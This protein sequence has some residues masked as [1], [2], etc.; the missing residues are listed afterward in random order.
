M[1]KQSVESQK[2]EIEFRKKLFQQQVEGKYIFNDEFDTKGIDKIL[3]DRMQKTSEQMIFL[4]KT[5][6]GLSPFIEIGAER[7]QRSLVMENEIGATGCAVDISYDMLRSCEYYKSLFN[8]SRAPFRICCDANQLPFKSNSIPFVFCYETLHHF[9]DPTPIVKEIH[10]VLIPGGNF[11]FD[12]EPFRKILHINL[13]KS[14]KIY[15]KE[16]LNAG[17]IRKIFDYFFSVK[18][19]N[20]VEHGIIENEAIPLKIWKQALN[21][22]LEKNVK[23]R[24]L[25]NLDTDLY[26]PKNYF[27]NILA[28]LFGGGIS[29][30]CRKSG[31]SIKQNISIYEI[32]IC[33]SCIENGYE[34][35]IDQKNYSF[36]CSHCGDE[37]PILDNVTFLFTS[38]KLQEL[39]P[40]VYKQIG[41][42]QST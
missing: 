23:L 11:F 8:K 30:I 21:C 17:Y 2:G 28:F 41:K 18:S 22:F 33:P 12:E 4:E 40:E 19:S 14:K 29:G 1:K 39:Y 10:R 42:N 5:G 37:F 34:S 31:D 38:G 35:K 24:F 3:I 7:C 16:S 32:L 13:Y 27:K 20:E 15:S 6:V 26:N 36:I 25:K 9:P